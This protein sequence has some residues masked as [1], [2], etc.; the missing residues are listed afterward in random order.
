M[1]RAVLASLVIAIFAVIISCNSEKKADVTPLV[2][3]WKK[4]N[5]DSLNIVLELTADYAWNYFKNDSLLEKGIFELKD[6]SFIMKHAAEEEKDHGHS[7]A[8]GHGHAKPDD[9]VYKYMLNETKTELKLT[10]G[11]KTSVFNKL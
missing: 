1:K 3:K 7:H 5:V 10:H 6:D 4:A 11:E 8:D 2:G 9:H